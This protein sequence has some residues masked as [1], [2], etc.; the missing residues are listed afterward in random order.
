MLEDKGYKIQYN[1]ETVKTDDKIKK[2]IKESK[3]IIVENLAKINRRALYDKEI[4]LT[5]TEK[6]IKENAVRRAKYLNIKFTKINKDK[7]FDYLVDDKQFTHFCTYKLMMDSDDKLDDKMT[8]QLQKDFNISNT[9]NLLTKINLIKQL[10]GIL[11]IKFLDI[12]T[13]KDVKKFNEKVV[14]KKQLKNSIKNV[15]RSS[16]DISDNDFKNWYYQLIQMYK[17]VLGCDIFNKKH[18]NIKD[19]IFII[20]N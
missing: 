10:E 13:S 19:V 18:T 3:E 16:R 12:D 8:D 17:N 6:K 14:V 20:I 7:Y 15:F 9:K 5:D 1:T 2:E 4:T 11:N